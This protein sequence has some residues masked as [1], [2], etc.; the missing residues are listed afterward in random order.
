M[1]L[2]ANFSRPCII[3]CVHKHARARFN[4]DIYLFSSDGTGCYYTLKS[5]SPFVGARTRANINEQYINV[6]YYYYYSV[7]EQMALRLYYAMIYF[8]SNFLK[9]L[10][11]KKKKTDLIVSDRR[12]YDY[13]Q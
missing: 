11:K 3:T 9:R 6:R 12:K 4:R 10:C 7:R 5:V 13:Y 8:P 1:I 2:L